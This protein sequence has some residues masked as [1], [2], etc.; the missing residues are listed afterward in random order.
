MT[1]LFIRRG[2]LLLAILLVLLALGTWWWRSC[3]VPDDEP[4]SAEELA[5]WQA[6]QDSL[7]A[8]GQAGDE[9]EM[10]VR[11]ELFP[12]DPNHDDSLTLRRLGLTP[13]QVGNMMKYRRK[14]GLWRSADDF[15]R[16]YG[17]A[18]KDFQRL[19]PYIRIRPED[20]RPTYEDRYV[21]PPAERPQYERVEKY[22]PGTVIDLNLADTNELKRV[23]GIGSYY[24]RKICSYRERLGGFVHVRQLDEVEGLPSGISTW[25]KVD[26]SARPQTINLN[27]ATFKEIVRHPYVSYE[28]TKAIMR[29]REKYGPMRDW[30]DLSLFKEFTPEDFNRMKPYF[31]IK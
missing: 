14:G 22:A 24:A 27:R 10:D 6:W 30:R 8:A 17:L 9:G 12:F 25:F 11:A 28:Q 20:R 18:P 19:R 23:P 26:D 4:I 2:R 7:R 5:A 15:A 16:L 1:P 13:W 3:S 31:V 21:S 29:Y